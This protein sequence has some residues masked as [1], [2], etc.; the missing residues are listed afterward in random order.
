MTEELKTMKDVINP[1]N[2]YGRAVEIFIEDQKREAINHI[3]IN[4]AKIKSLST[5]MQTE[6]PA[7][8]GTEIF[9]IRSVNQW[10]QYFFNIT[11]EEL[12]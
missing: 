1:P 7:P 9:A 12:P 5:R 3:Q 2:Q 8:L 11:E 6:D 10:I 4:R